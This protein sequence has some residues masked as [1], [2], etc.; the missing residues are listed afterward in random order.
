[1]TIQSVVLQ[2]FSLGHDWL[3]DQHYVPL[4]F[5]ILAQAYLF[6]DLVFAD[7]QSKTQGLN[8]FINQL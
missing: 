6:K 1:M 2:I 3:T 5:S 8:S 7:K 4:E